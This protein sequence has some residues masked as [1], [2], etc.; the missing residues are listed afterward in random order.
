M[1]E[2]GGH[3]VKSA[4]GGMSFV[5]AGGGGGGASG[6]SAVAQATRR[7]AALDRQA[8]A[9]YDR[10][11][12]EISGAQKVMDFVSRRISAQGN[13]PTAADYAEYNAASARQNRARDTISMLKRYAGL[14][15]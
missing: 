2:K 10:A 13:K 7:T 14:G 11:K 8:Q 1:A 4:G 5:A 15:E 9:L 6:E 12:E 3:W